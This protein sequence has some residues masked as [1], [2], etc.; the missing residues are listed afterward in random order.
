MAAYGSSTDLR[1]LEKHGKQYRA[2]L[3]VP[4]K[5]RHIVG[6]AALKKSLRT[7]SL[8]EAQR[9]R[10]SAL[11][12]LRNQLQEIVRKAKSAPLDP[13][14]ADALDL[15]E[16]RHELMGYI[17]KEGRSSDIEGLAMYE[18]ELFESRA[19]RIARQKN[20]ARA[21]EYL[22]IIR[23]ERTPIT[24][25]LN[26]WMADLEAQDLAKRTSKHYRNSVEELAAFTGQEGLPQTL[27]AF[28]RRHAGDFISKRFIQPKV[29]HKTAAKF[30]SAL[31]SYWRWLESRG[32]LPTGTDNPWL[33]QPKPKAPK[34]QRGSKWARQKERPFT[35]DEVLALLDPKASAEDPV[36]RDFMLI[37][38]LS[39]MRI[40]EIASLRVEDVD[41]EALVLEVVEAKTEAGV[42]VVPIHLML[43]GIIKHRTAGKARGNWLF[44]EL[45]EY[46]PESLSERSMVVSKRFTTFRRRLGVDERVEG[47]RRSLVNFHSFRRW[48]IRSARNALH[49][50]AV[51]YDPWTI[52]DVVGHERGTMGLDMT[53]GVYP[54]RASMEALQACVRAVKLPSQCE[55]LSERH[56]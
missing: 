35:D 53:M 19:H 14:I 46:P 11:G 52:A 34:P 26:E 23:G 29:H 51:G 25:Y 54:G 24:T 1:H 33:R 32:H 10:W 27:E 5:L 39:G 45:P 42:R 38:A 18:T 8:T 22:G 37:A 13:D 41:L 2:K 9:L 30:I 40:E 6:K 7:D 15:R 48:F 36:L 3:D 43:E 4:R 12:E 49:A 21:N 44:P 16:F 50:G 28:S 56:L 47:K 55:K 17:E 20:P 31:S